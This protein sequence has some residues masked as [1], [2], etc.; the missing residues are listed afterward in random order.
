MQTVDDAMR[1][2]RRGR[3]LQVQIRRRSSKLDPR[4]AFN[5]SRAG[6]A[7]DKCEHLLRSQDGLGALP[8]VGWLISGAVALLAGAAAYVGLAT[9]PTAAEEAKTAVRWLA[10]AATVAG[11]VM[12]A[13]TTKAAA[14]GV[15]RRA[16]DLL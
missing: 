13:A 9:V 8:L 3:R 6:A 2:L 11:I 4:M 1:L 5:V 14:S 7:L 15:S 10:R 16:R 12:I